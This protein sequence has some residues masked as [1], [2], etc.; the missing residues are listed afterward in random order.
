RPAVGGAVVADRAG[1]VGRP[2]DCHADRGLAGVPGS[3]R[4]GLAVERATHHICAWG[5]SL[6]RALAVSARQPHDASCGGAYALLLPRAAGVDARARARGSGDVTQ[7]RKA[8]SR[9]ALSRPV[10]LGDRLTH[11]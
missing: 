6:A 11:E 5:V 9:V 8:L 2:F 4:T 7:S 3:G 10:T 1:D